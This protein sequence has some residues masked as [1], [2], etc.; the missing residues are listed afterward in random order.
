MHDNDEILDTNK[1]FLKAL[2]A[3][4]KKI[5]QYSI[6]CVLWSI[7]CIF[8]VP[9]SFLSEF[10]LLIM[11]FPWFIFF[12][13]MS[14]VYSKARESFWM[15]ISTK[16]GW[17]Y[18][19]H[20]NILKEKALLFGIGHSISVGHGI[21]GNYQDRPF[22]IFEYEYAVGSGKQKTTYSF[23]V[24][25]VKFTG[26]FPHLYLNYKDD[27]YANTPALISS[28]A[29]LSLPKEFEDKFK[30][31]SPKEYEIETLEI[32]T[33]DFFTHLLNCGWKHDMEFV[34]GELLIYRRSQ[35]NNFTDLDTELNT[36]KKFVDFLSPRLNRLTFTHIGDH[37]PLL[38][39]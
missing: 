17:T 3:N 5:T 11:G 22:H 30:L 36:I 4:K 6:L 35:F 10:G 27:G 16:Y 2:R 32:F 8:L 9:W 19:H 14:S 24:F 25:E 38:S 26:N 39:G 7:G 18:T 15:Q 28:L 21:S 33:P 1:A 34:D 31:Y 13:Y 20:K 29:K 23:T 37:S 12:G